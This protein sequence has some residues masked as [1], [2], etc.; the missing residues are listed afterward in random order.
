VSQI[1]V[2]LCIGGYL[3]EKVDEVSE[4][5]LVDSENVWCCLVPFGT[6]LTEII[7]QVVRSAKKRL[8][9]ELVRFK[10]GRKG[11]SNCRGDAI[12]CCIG[13]ATKD[14]PRT[15]QGPAKDRPRTRRE[16]PIVGVSGG[17]AG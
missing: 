17:S 5:R 9:V 8:G 2:R 1:N 10:R 4:S 12:G 15:G 11:E 7:R 3:V 13:G 14:R 16:T 6:S